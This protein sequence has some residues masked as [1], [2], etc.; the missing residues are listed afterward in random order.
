MAAYTTIDD[1]G[2]FFSTTLYAGN[3]STNAI[4]GVGFQPDFCWLKNR[5]GVASHA[6][7]DTARGNDKTIRTNNSNAEYTNSFFDSFDSDGFTVSTSENDVNASG[8]DFVSWNWI[9]GTTSGITTDGSTTI[10]PSAYSFNATSGFSILKYTGN[11]TS[12]A[13]LAHGLGVKPGFLA[14]KKVNSAGDNFQ[15][16]HHTVGYSNSGDLALDTTS[17]QGAQ[18]NFSGEPDATNIFLGGNTIN[19]GNTDTFICYA[20][21]GINGFSKM[22][23]YTGNGNADGTFVYTGFR[24]AFVLNKRYNSSG[25]WKLHNSKAPA[26]NVC[27]LGLA[28]NTNAAESAVDGVD[29]QLD[30]LSNGF[31]WRATDTDVNAAGSTYLYMAL[32]ESPFV[33]SEGVPTNAR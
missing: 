31:K 1:A 25:S 22:G 17:G 33:N 2:L 4:T 27:N 7:Q 20:F 13:G 16:Y 12:G 6:L 28:T 18:T 8:D 26:F 15:I 21:A 5:S 10:T 19:N 30:L 3:S 14:M 24:P 23:G 11:S 9:G 32:A 29:R